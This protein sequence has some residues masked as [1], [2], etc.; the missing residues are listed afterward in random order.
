MASFDRLHERRAPRVRHR[1]L[2]LLGGLSACATSV[3]V[4]GNA[5]AGEPEAA[6]RGE[7][8][9]IETTHTAH[10]WRPIGSLWLAPTFQIVGPGSELDTDCDNLGA[11]SCSTPA[12]IGGMIG[13]SFGYMRSR[14]IVDGVLMAGG[15]VSRPSARFDG[16]VPV[17]YGNP[18]RS[19]PP[20]TEDFTMLRTGGVL[21]LRLSRMTEGDNWRFV[22][23]GGAGLAI[24]YAT[25]IR[26]VTT[27]DGLEDRP[28]FPSGAVYASPAFLLSAAADWRQTKN[29][30]IIFGLMALSEI[31]LGDPATSEDPNRSVSGNGDEAPVATPAYTLASGFGLT[32]MPVVGLR[33]G[34]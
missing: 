13:G 11:A 4:H 1:W 12:P 26:E 22:F 19:T 27:D 30:D 32:L 6:A 16:R 20:R 15:D 21:A 33:F 8:A 9:P 25:L 34:P 17:P 29:L 10:R 7:L 5:A 3:L 14:W 28:F 23:G 2:G 24:R 31:A 18:L